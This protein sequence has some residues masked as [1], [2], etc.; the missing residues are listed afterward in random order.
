MRPKWE[1]VSAIFL[2]YPKSAENKVIRM[3]K[4]TKLWIRRVI[5]LVALIGLAIAI[6]QITTL[7]VSN[8]PKVGEEAPDFKLKQLNGE[9]MQLSQLR[10]KAVMINFWGTWCEPCRTEMPAMQKAYEKYKDQGFEIVAVNIAETEIA[11]SNFVE[12]YGLTFPIL[13]D[14]QKEIVRQYKIGPLPSSIFVDPQ[15]K[16]TQFIEGP[17]EVAQLELY[18][19]PILPRK[20]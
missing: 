8:K 2:I 15:G 17:L 4:E 9:E 20:Q 1:T 16:I 5:L 12:D 3:K 11:V 19:N 14:A 7:D 13:M 10:G 6:Y 18:I